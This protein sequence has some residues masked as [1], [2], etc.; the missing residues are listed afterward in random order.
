MGNDNHFYLGKIYDLKKKEITD[1]RL[2]YDPPDLTTHMIVTGMTGSGKTGLCVGLLEEAALQG[3]PALIIDPKGDLTNLA[4]TFPNL[5]PADFEPWIDKNSVRRENKTVEQVAEK[6]AAL[7]KDGLNDWGIG[8]V[9]IEELKKSVE[10]VIYTPGSTT[11]VPVNILSSFAA[12]EMGW[13]ENEEILREKISATVTAILTLVGMKDIDP[14]RSK[15]HILLANIIEH[16]WQDNHSLSMTELI[17]EIQTPPFDQLGAFS[18]DDFFTKKD[19]MGLAILL[20]NVLASPTFQS[21]I[22]GPPLDI[23]SML[24]TNDGKPKHAIF[25]LAHLDDAERMFFITLIYAAIETWMR[26]QRG[27]GDL[28]ALVYF[29]EIHGYLPP[30]AN[31]PSKP[32][33]IRLLKTARA[34]G[35]GLILTTQNP[36]DVDYKALSNAGTWMVGR[37]QT[38]QDKQRLLDGLDSAAG[39]IQR[40]DFDRL[41]SA[42]GKRV[43]LYHNVNEKKPEVFH[44]RWAMSYL[45]GPLTLTQIPELNTLLGNNTFQPEKARKMK[46]AETDPI[47][48]STGKSASVENMIPGTVAQF[49]LLDEAK[50]KSGALTPQLIAIANVRYLRQ[51]PPVDHERTLISLIE[52]P[53]ESGQNWERGIGVLTS[54][55]EITTSIPKNEKFG[56]IPAFMEKNT[57]WESQQRDFEHWIYETDT[58][59][60]RT[61]KALNISV[62][63]E[64]SEEKFRDQWTQASTKKTQEELKKIETQYASK[65]KTAKDKVERQV[66]KIDKYKDQLNSRRA[67]TALKVGESLFKLVAKGKISGVSSSSSK[68]RMSAE[69]KARMEEA[70]TI[71]KSY[72]EDLEDLQQ[73]LNDKKAEMQENWLDFE[74]DITEIKISP[75]KQNIRI[76]RF[77]VL[78]RN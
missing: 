53:Q 32:L 28:R 16:H 37:L 6:T 29:D 19:R 17:K 34:F 13:E 59:S 11:G 8:K 30:V 23:E 36:V 70:E 21:W 64:V 3:I 66:L 44:T 72:Q 68:L 20:N 74:K 43:F 47:R 54:D 27:T 60:I 18:L 62:G 76:S 71:L 51:S 42:L 56:T 57:W 33:I 48:S 14:L 58:V 67:D 61:S 50:P 63:P 25:Y 65:I 35:V 26:K 12:P 2:T 22:E 1:D 78:W 15:E 41:I 10:R 7:W 75:T 73:A 5:S 39:G 9:Q 55:K 40:S 46:E 49:F 4:L 52:I 31:P 69:A 24:Y 77:G 38:D 45:A